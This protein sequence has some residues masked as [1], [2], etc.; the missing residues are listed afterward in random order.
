MSA[1]SSLHLSELSS[2]EATG[3]FSSN[4]SDVVLSD[5]EWTDTVEDCHLEDFVSFVGPR[6]PLG[7]DA[8]PVDYF[9]QLFPP[10]THQHTCFYCNILR[11]FSAVRVIFMGVKD[12][13]II[14]SGFP[15]V[16]ESWKSPGI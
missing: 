14:V 10:K 2:G 5:E 12:I 9:L 15:Q 6:K 16:L 11:K 8:K 3:G 1:V 4:E 13:I 7:H